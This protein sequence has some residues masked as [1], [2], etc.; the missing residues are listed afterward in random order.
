MRGLAPR[1][2]EHYDAC[3]RN[4]DAGRGEPFRDRKVIDTGNNA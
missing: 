1:N 2:V 4:A 3:G